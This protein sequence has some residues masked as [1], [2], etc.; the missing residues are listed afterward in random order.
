V[1]GGCARC[2]GASGERN[3]SLYNGKSRAIMQKR[4]QK[5]EEFP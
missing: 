5:L 2:A 4:T 3:L 1:G